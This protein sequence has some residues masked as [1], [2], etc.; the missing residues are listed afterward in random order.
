MVSRTLAENSQSTFRSSPIRVQHGIIIACASRH[1]RA[2]SAYGLVLTRVRLLVIGW[3]PKVV[4]DVSAFRECALRQSIWSTE[5][6]CNA[7]A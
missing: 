7:S 2:S 3:M 1:F 4:G 6:P 5:I